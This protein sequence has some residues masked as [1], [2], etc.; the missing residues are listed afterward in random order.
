MIVYI[1][2]KL[3]SILCQFVIVSFSLNVSGTCYLEFSTEEAAMKVDFLSLCYII[4]RNCSIFKLYPVNNSPLQAVELDGQ[5]LCDRKIIV[6]KIGV[7]F[8]LPC[9]LT[10]RSFVLL[11]P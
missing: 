11:F 8:T 6:R 1:C 2:R 5:I 4:S 3:L 7:E 9:E 10:F